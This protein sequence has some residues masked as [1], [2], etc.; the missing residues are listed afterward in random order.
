MCSMLAGDEYAGWEGYGQV[1][2]GSMGN[3]V[4]LLLKWRGWMCCL[5]QS[6]VQTARTAFT[7]APNAI[8]KNWSMATRKRK[9]TTK[10]L[11]NTAQCE[12]RRAVAPVVLFAR[13]YC[14]R[15]GGSSDTMLAR[16]TEEMMM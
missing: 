13:L 7:V 4:V 2:L 1:L 5:G 16:S 10:A 11:K 6:R 12:A 14:S 8:Q 9:C 3:K 15:D